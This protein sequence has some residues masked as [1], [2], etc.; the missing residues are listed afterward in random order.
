MPLATLRLTVKPDL[1]ANR[2]IKLFCQCSNI[3]H[4]N[5]ILF[6]DIPF[7][8]S[9]FNL[10]TE[11]VVITTDVTA[12]TCVNFIAL[13]DSLGLE[14]QET[15]SLMLSGPENVQFGNATLSITINDADGM[16]MYVHTHCINA[17][18]HHYSPCMHTCLLFS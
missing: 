15:L 16:Y 12:E 14:G 6:T 13:A 18:I 10:V 7:L 8:S 1:T 5:Q 4:N 9:D 2:I 3:I 11:Q 17:C